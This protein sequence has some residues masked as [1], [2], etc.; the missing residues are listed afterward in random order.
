[1]IVL[2]SCRSTK[3]IGTAI[4]KKDTVQVVN[5]SNPKADSIAFMKGTLQKLD[6]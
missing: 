3:N 4:A 2:A 1:M 6:G 5:T